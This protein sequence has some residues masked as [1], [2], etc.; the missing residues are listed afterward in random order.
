MAPPYGVLLVTGGNTHQEN[1]GLS[2]AEDP[3][4]RVVGVTDEADVSPRRAALNRRLAEEMHV[5]YLPDLAEALRRDDVA[6]CSICTEHDR[7]GRVSI[8]CAAAGKHVYLDKPLA[9]SLAEADRLVDV[10]RVRGVQ[11]QMFT[12]IGFPYAQRARAVVESGRLGELRAI[13]CD[14]MFAKGWA[15]DAVPRRPRKE[16]EQ[17]SS[18]L[19]PDA[20]RELFNI[21]VYSLTLIRWLTGREIVSVYATTSNYFFEENL[22]R[23][24]EDF[25][26][27]ALT[28]ET[29]IT[30]TITAGRI[31]WM[32]HPGAGPNVIHLQGERGSMRLDSYRP[33]LEIQSD[34]PEW[35][36]PVRDPEDP[37]GF[38]RSSQVRAGIQPRPEWAVPGFLPAR[39]DASLFVDCVERGKPAEVTAFDG[40]KAVEAL[41]A[42]YRSAATGEV[43]RLPLPR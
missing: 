19:V 11:S 17:P 26:M 9:G 13:H 40:A 3:R 12:Q 35:R 14:L 30:A 24:F 37:M 15:S 27:M 43:V 39:P 18:F 2:L 42:G 6:I 32:S 20:K 8:A 1:Y 5:P 10:V 4:C 29:G 23:D 41:F 28:L 34:G 38:W 36:R 16:T 31:G 21:A 22:R 33:R 25:G 7:Q